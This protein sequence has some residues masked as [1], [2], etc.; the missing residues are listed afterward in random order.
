MLYVYNYKYKE[1]KGTQLTH[2]KELDYVPYTLF[3]NPH[4]RLPTGYNVDS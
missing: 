4:P 2:L 1:L 3:E